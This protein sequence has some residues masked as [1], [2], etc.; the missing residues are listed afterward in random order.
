M[1]T[2]VGVLTMEDVER[3]RHTR[4]ISLPATQDSSEEI[5]RRK[6]PH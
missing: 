3:R 2:A 4:S 5:I 1:T 6:F